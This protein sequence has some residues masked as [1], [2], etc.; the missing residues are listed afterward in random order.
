MT[1]NPN[2][3]DIGGDTEDS[4]PKYKAY[5]IAISPV[6]GVYYKYYSK[7]RATSDLINFSHYFALVSKMDQT[8]KIQAD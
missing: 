5:S 6:A 1:K 4:S 8:R 7:S 2:L 3:I